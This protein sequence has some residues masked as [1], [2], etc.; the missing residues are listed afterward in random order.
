[1]QS[2]ELGIFFSSNS[3][4]PIDFFFFSCDLWQAI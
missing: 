4:F 1:M 3:S 2:K